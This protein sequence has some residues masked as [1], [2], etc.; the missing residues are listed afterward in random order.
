[1]GGGGNCLCAQFPQWSHVWSPQ[2]SGCQEGTGASRAD[3]TKSL[4][5]DRSREGASLPVQLSRQPLV[6]PLRTRCAGRDS[7]V[8][9]SVPPP[10]AH[11][12]SARP[13]PECTPQAAPQCACTTWAHHSFTD[14]NARGNDKSAGGHDGEVRATRHRFRL[15]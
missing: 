3:A 12:P 11:S 6:K 1:M 14:S 2:R 9:P 5:N 13:S 8:A 15:G 4:W 7:L 10:S